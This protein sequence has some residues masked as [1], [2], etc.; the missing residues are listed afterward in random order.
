MDGIIIAALIVAAI[1][2]ICAAILVIASKFMSVPVDTKF[3]EI[4]ECLP[5]ANCGACG[6]SGCDGYAKALASGET[7]KTNLCIPGA[8]NVSQHL[9]N[10][11]GTEFVDVVEQVATMHCMG[12]CDKASKPNEYNG[13]KSCVAASLLPTSSSSCGFGCIGLGDC[14]SVCPNKAICIEN[15]IAHIDT[16]NCVGCG[17]CAKACPRHVIDLMPDIER[18]IIACSNKEK[19]VA[20]KAKCSVGCIGC[21]LC[22]RTCSKGAITVVDNLAKIDYDLCD[23]CGDC[24]NKC[25]AKCIVI[26]DF[27]GIHR[28]PFD[29]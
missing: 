3:T 5:G 9:S 21:G 17:L 23:G 15:G 7:D 28:F 6:F 4:R 11:L 25:P 10:V 1:G 12:D 8:D 29:R 13:I 20:V 2:L 19:G 18:T 26:S 22:Q 24:A 16:R 27:S 14:V